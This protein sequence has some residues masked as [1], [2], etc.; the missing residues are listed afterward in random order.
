M[1][2]MM[3]SQTKSRF[4]SCLYC[5]ITLIF[6]SI[7]DAWAQTT[8]SGK[9]TQA[10]NRESIQ[11]VT[12]RLLNAADSVVNATSTNTQ[13]TYQLRIPKAGEYTLR[14]LYIGMATQDHPLRISDQQSAQQID[15]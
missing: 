7:N 3:Y 5:L 1:P 9:V 10:E 6:F 14:F 11:G 4:S 13:G 12:V 15:V 8:I 2:I